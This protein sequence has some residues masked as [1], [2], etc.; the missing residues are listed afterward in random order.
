MRS[1]LNSCMGPGEPRKTKI[2]RETHTR[3]DGLQRKTG[4][5]IAWTHDVDANSNEL[6][7]F[8]WKAGV[9]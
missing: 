8:L 7:E 2:E 6:K 5:T 4:W 1:E 9:S 3:G